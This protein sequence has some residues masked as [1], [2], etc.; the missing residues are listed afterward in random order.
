MTGFL[1]VLPFAATLFTAC[2]EPGPL[3]TGYVEGDFTLIAPVA[4]GWRT[5]ALVEAAY[6]SSAAPMTPIEKRP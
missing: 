4:D 5:M 1:C 2:A 6:A 3:A